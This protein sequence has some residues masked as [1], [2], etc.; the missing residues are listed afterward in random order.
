MF[1][2]VS[3]HSCEEKLIGVEKCFCFPPSSFIVS[4]A[5]MTRLYSDALQ[6]AKF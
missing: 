4:A 5:S 3:I 2:F 6:V 1:L